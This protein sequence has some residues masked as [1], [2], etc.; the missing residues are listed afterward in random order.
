MKN[1]A[2]RSAAPSAHVRLPRRSTA[3]R[4]LVREMPVPSNLI[5]VIYIPPQIPNQAH[6]RRQQRLRGDKSCY[7]FGNRRMYYNL[8]VLTRGDVLGRWKRMLFPKQGIRPVVGI[9]CIANHL[10]EHGQ[11][12]RSQ[13]QDGYD[14]FHFYSVFSECV[15]EMLFTMVSE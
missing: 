8:V 12:S 2:L 1:A 13:N 6:A 10:C 9:H 3:S 5:A 15:A 14:C 4:M 7:A 11:Q